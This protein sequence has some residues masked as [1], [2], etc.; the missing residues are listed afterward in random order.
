MCNELGEKTAVV[1]LTR[2]AARRQSFGFGDVSVGGGPWHLNLRINLFEQ[3]L[4]SC[5]HQT[6]WLSSIRSD[7]DVLGPQKGTQDRQR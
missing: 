2:C 6:W 1:E 3:V 5:G 7:Q 4:K